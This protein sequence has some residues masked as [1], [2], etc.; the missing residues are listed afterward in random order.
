MWNIFWTCL[1]C[2][3]IFVRGLVQG[4]FWSSCQQLRPEVNFLMK[5]DSKETSYNASYEAPLTQKNTFCHCDTHCH[6]LSLSFDKEINIARW[7][8]NGKSFSVSNVKICSNLQMDAY[9]HFKFCHSRRNGSCPGRL[10]V[11]THRLSAVW[12]KCTDKPKKW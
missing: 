5:T 4:F 2:Q 1:S 10:E 12:R 3:W 9:C 6:C 7:S 11:M 8:S